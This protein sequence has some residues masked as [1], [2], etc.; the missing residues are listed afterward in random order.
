MTGETRSSQRL[1]PQGADKLPREVRDGTRHDVHVAVPLAPLV[2]GEILEPRPETAE[3]IAKKPNLP[4]FT[5][6]RARTNGAR[7]ALLQKELDNWS[8]RPIIASTMMVHSHVEADP[9]GASVSASRCRPGRSAPARPLGSFTRHVDYSAV[10]CDLSL[11]AAM[12]TLVC[13]DPNNHMRTCSVTAFRRS[14]L[15]HSR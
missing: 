1:L 4:P 3:P 5:V 15:I 12:Q 8:R 6:K 10:A 11:I 2:D 14:S 7:S 9:E 13:E